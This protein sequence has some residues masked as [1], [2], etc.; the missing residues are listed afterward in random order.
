MS[1]FGLTGGALDRSFSIALRLLVEDLKFGTSVR[2]VGNWEGQRCWGGC[3]ER[4]GT[5]LTAELR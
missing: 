4:R 2:G 3:V 1:L 5:Q